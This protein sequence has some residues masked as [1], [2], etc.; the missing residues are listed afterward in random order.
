MRV[1]TRPGRLA[2]LALVVAT[3]LPALL[4][5]T[6][7]AEADTV[8]DPAVSPAQVRPAL[9]D[10]YAGDHASGDDTAAAECFADAL[11]EQVTP[12]ELR[13]GGVLDDRFAP[14]TEP[15]PLAEPV[16][17]AWT[18]AQQACT[19]F[20]AES[21]QAQEALTKGRL[22]AAAYAACL[23]ARLPDATVRDATVSTLMARWKDPAVSEM[24]RA[25]SECSALSVPQ[26]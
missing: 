3:T 23:D 1:H 13:D 19:D 7:E 26:D 14:R 22:D 20:V 24:S 5:C 8:P 4:G 21:T 2:A 15:A 9:V 16:A 25:Q 17:V 11:L 12:E 10:L 18:E 6:A